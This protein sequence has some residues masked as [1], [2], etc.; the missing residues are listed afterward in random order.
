MNARGIGQN[1]L[2]LAALLLVS[3]L[4]PL[5]AINESTTSGNFRDAAS[6]S[7]IYY[8][9]GPG[10]PLASDK[11]EARIRPGH[12]IIL[13]ADSWYTS[14]SLMVPAMPA[15]MGSADNLIVELSGGTFEIKRNISIE[16]MFDSGSSSKTLDISSG[17][18]VT[19]DRFVF[20]NSSTTLNING[21]LVI[22]YRPVMSYGTFMLTP[23]F[24]LNQNPTINFTN[25]RLEFRSGIRL[26]LSNPNVSA[27]SS[28]QDMRFTRQVSNS[29]KGNVPD[30]G[31][32]IPKFVVNR[33][34]MIANLGFTYAPAAGVTL[35]PVNF[36]RTSI[37]LR[38]NLTLGSR[39]SLQLSRFTLTVNGNLIM[40][41]NTSITLTTLRGRGSAGSL[42]ING[43]LDVLTNH[44]SASISMLPDSA[45]LAFNGITQL[46]NN[47]ATQPAIF[48]GG[49]SIEIG[50][51]NNLT[52]PPS[53]QVQLAGGRF[54]LNEFV[55]KSSGTLNLAQNL[56]LRTLKVQNGSFQANNYSLTITD[57][58]ILSGG[59][60]IPSTSSVVMNGGS[61]STQNIQGDMTFYNLSINNNGARTVNFEGS[62]NYTVQNDFEARGDSA[63]ARLRLEGKSE[64]YI[65]LKGTGEY[66]F[67]GIRNSNAS[68]S[69]ASL[70]P[71]LGMN[72]SDDFQDLG[73][74]TSW[75]PPSPPSIVSA[76][77]DD[78]DNED[79]IFSSGDTI[80]FNFDQNTNYS[81]GV[82]L[83]KAGIDELFDLSMV[84][85][86]SDYIGE[87]QD[88]KTFIITIVNSAGASPPELGSTIFQLK[89]S[90]NV[91]ALEGGLA[92]TSESPPL[93][94]DFG[95]LTNLSKAKPSPSVFRPSVN[96]S[97]RFIN[98][99]GNTNLTVYTINGRKIFE[100]KIQ[101][102]N[103]DWNVKTSSGLSLGSGVY[104]V[105]MITE[106]GEKKIVKFVV[107][108]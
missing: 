24:S 88:A 36:E 82:K 38:G 62:K 70:K 22:Q 47:E 31:T 98:I 8:P 33:P 89:S 21:G 54:S 74:N 72:P 51:S 44:T 4:D 86:G 101:G 61:D 56:P 28:I 45:R 76:V 5:L 92:S 27:G 102:N 34:D 60:F 11:T 58:L 2:C 17:A 97:I 79:T 30:W 12:T 66:A 84:S 71:L 99:V 73:G 14:K 103:F 68:G 6:W 49:G 1:Y 16:S 48:L 53:N 80:T 7:E 50:G 87:W 29:N 35:D 107:I 63:T 81:K 96:R 67:L 9:G 83:D 15:T 94:G 10:D 32:E 77:A 42:M 106:N 3:W 91:T 23:L 41:N 57:D 90:G 64:W 93:T 59:N 13:Q 104:V 20:T 85:L 18:M 39:S 95:K 46:T 78:P 43:N 105:H 40:R 65:T 108:R 55:W 19:A 25:A 75:F 100:K 26:D 37:T 52:F 69:L